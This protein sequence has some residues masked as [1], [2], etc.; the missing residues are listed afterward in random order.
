[1]LISKKDLLAIT[2]ISYGQLYRWKRSGLIPDE[3]FIKQSAYTGQET[4]FPRE[5]IISRIRSIQDLKDKYSLEELA[6]MFSPEVSK[7]TYG[8]EDLEK[9]SEIAP[10]LLNI[11]IEAFG[12]KDFLYTELVLMVIL[13]EAKEELNLSN[14]KA[15]AMISGIKGLID[16]ISST[17]AMVSF[18]NAGEECYIMIYPEHTM[19]LMDERLDVVKEIRIEDVAARVKLQYQEQLNIV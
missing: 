14:E 16:D 11:F 5:Q 1:M 9:I 17:D 4:F 12:K 13:S 19:L 18:V 3:W 15:V 8:Q 6:R 10:E 7:R 2:G